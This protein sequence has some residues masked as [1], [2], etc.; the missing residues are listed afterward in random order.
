MFPLKITYVIFISFLIIVLPNI[1]YFSRLQRSITPMR[2]VPSTNFP[3][4]TPY[5]LKHTPRPSSLLSQPFLSNFSSYHPY[6]DIEDTTQVAEQDLACKPTNFG[7]SKENGDFVFP[8]YSY[9]KCSKLVK[10]PAPQLSF[11]YEKNIFE[12]K[13]EE[14]TPYYILEPTK[15][16][17]RLYQLNEIMDILEPEKYKGPVKITKEEFAIGSCDGKTYNSAIYNPRFNQTAFQAAKDIKHKPL[18]VMLL[19]VDSYSRRHFFRKMPKTVAFLN[20]LP[21]NYSVFDFKLHNIYGGSSVENMVPIFSGMN[22][23]DLP[24]VEK[25]TPREYDVLKNDSMW[26]YFRSKGFV[27]LFG[28]EDCDY[29]FPNAIGRYQEVDHLI[30]SFYC[31]AK[32]YMKLDTEIDTNY[33]QRCLGSYMSHWYTLNYTQ[34]FT[35]MYRGANQWIYIHLNT[36]HEATGQHAMTLDEDLVDFLQKYL[37]DYGKTHELAIFLHADHGMRYGNWYQDIEAYQENKLPAFF[38]IGSN[39]LLERIPESYEN[40]I[41]NG[42]RLTTKKD[43]RPTINYLAEFPYSV[44]P[45]THTGK[46]VNLFRE[47]APVNRT[48][49]ELNISPFDCSCLVVEEIEGYEDDEELYD[50]VMTVI[51][52]S[53]YKINAMVHTPFTGDYNICEKLSFR[54][55][56]NVY[57]LMLNNKV[58]ELQIKFGVNENK[59][60][61]FE[62]FAFVGTHV[63]STVLIASSY[64]RSIVPYV[65]RGYRSRV[66][67][68]GIKRKDKYAGVCE[69]VA[70][71]LNI[72]AEYCLCNPDTIDN[73]QL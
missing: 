63:R 41:T 2:F 13:C 68:F 3:T 46:F 60:A 28:L 54:K 7:Y 71:K 25:D 20:D 39:S 37:N 42:L 66:K 45:D 24:Y 50:L 47:L 70:R 33:V 21:S 43:L 23:L 59:N 27:T 65:Y 48:C 18:I 64:R 56:M 4:V 9:E 49:D 31:T 5:Y 40:L 72:K 32:G 61:V 62:V 26:G 55:V 44:A 30:R 8:P 11:D 19:T 57:G 67:I 6:L 58:E 52:E 69:N 53:I 14:G 38:F 34:E 16:K 29:Y 73:F 51:E 1:T 10:K 17:G 12:A 35:N 15:N 36:A 22:Y